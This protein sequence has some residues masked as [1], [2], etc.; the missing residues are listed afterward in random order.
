VIS[1]LP[2]PSLRLRLTLLT[3]VLVV[4]TGT[5]LLVLAALLVSP[6]IRDDG[7]VA[8]GT[9]I[10]LE[11]V[12]GT[13]RLVDFAAW[14]AARARAV[15]I[16]L[17]V[18]GLLALG[19]IALVGVGGSYLLT[20][21]ALRPLHEVTQ[22]ARRLSTATLDQR[23]AHDGPDDEVAEL[24]ETFDAMLARL[25]AAF[26][27]QQRFVANASHELR[28]PLA[29]MRTE[30][31]VTLGDPEVSVEELKRMGVVVR[32]SS[33]R[34]NQLIDS[35]LILARTQAA[36][37]GPNGTP[38]RV[39]LAEAARSALVA[40]A[41]DLRSADLTVRADLSPA[42]ATGDP[43]LLE[44]LV[45]N[46]VENAVRH[47]IPGGNIAVRTACAPGSVTVVVANTGRLIGPEEVPGLFEPFRRGGT[48]RTGSMGAGLGLSI[49]HAVVD[50]HGGT[51]Q[52]QP[53]AGG[54]LEI[55][56]SLPAR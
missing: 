35:L 37:T 10:T 18:K 4:G 44:R 24:A 5:L 31:D 38:A 50:A 1:R 17:L 30:V 48:E 46:L 33:A 21:R 45:G 43:S 23:I 51:V 42:I 40:N 25:A 39:D 19:A 26:A 52:A 49:V 28:T 12:H 15:E 36:A 14:Q 56:V 55:V 34:A 2:R 16:D 54:G 29:V 11:D 13:R 32:E 9:T 41:V 27:S 47:N 3:A 53:L 8:P 22:A 20:K 6:A 7:G